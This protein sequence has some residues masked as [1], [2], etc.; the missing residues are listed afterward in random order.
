[1]FYVYVLKSTRD[2]ELC[3]GSTKDLKKRLA[4]HNAGKVFSTRSRKPFV[5]IYYEAYR[6]EKDARTRESALKL[7][8]RARYHLKGRISE[9]LKT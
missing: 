4:E 9:S 5:L 6:A 7:R 8:G 1:M 2:E 3:V